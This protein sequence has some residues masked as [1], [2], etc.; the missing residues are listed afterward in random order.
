MCAVAALSAVRLDGPP[1]HVHY[2]VTTTT[3]L[4][5]ALAFIPWI[6]ERLLTAGAAFDFLEAS[7]S[8]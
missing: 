7:R 4:F 5:V 1:W 3:A 8:R 6:L 2:E